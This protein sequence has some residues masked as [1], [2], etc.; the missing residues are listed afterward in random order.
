MG[1]I[2]IWKDLDKSYL[3]VKFQADRIIF[4][5]VE[6]PR[7]P[8]IYDI[9]KNSRFSAL[10]FWER[11]YESKRNFG[12]VI[13]LEFN[14]DPSQMGN[15]SEPSFGYLQCKSAIFLPTSKTVTYRVVSA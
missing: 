8:K 5:W 7:K 11:F 13:L 12:N 1:P 9:S 14:V 10:I 6:R 15:G 3:G 4:G 2:N